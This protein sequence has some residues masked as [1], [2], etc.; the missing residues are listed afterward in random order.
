M[1]K[2]NGNAITVT[3]DPNAQLPDRYLGSDEDGP[4]YGPVSL[5]DAIIR[6]ASAKLV[7][8]GEKVLRE[9]V[10]EQMQEAVMREVDARLPA[11]I[12]AAFNEPVEV[13]DGFSS[14]KKSMRELI[15]D[16]VKQ[17]CKPRATN[18]G[19]DTTLDKTMREHVERAL[20]TEFRAEVDAAKAQIRKRLTA[21]A[22]ELIAA[23]SLR[24]VGIR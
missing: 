15:G 23:E 14:H 20:A 24:E 12:E 16:R 17:E 4:Q 22:A 1:S 13:G 11:I 2:T 9:L 19:N 8:V 3:I 7:G 10:T 5:Y 18:Y 21:K 6:D